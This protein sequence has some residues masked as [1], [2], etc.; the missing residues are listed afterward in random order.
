[1]NLLTEIFVQIGS[2]STDFGLNNRKEEGS[3]E[4]GS[5]GA[6]MGWIVFGHFIVR[7]D[8]KLID[9]SLFPPQTYTYIIKWE[10]TT[11]DSLI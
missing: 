8:W 5:M 7:L 1:M 9:P 3:K 6:L 4:K 2:A 11:S 10:H